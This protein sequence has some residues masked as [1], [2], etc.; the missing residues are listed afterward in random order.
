MMQATFDGMSESATGHCSLGPPTPK[1]IPGD[2]SNVGATTGVSTQL[3]GLRACGMCLQVRHPVP[4]PEAQPTREGSTFTLESGC[5][6]LTFLVCVVGWPGDDGRRQ[7]GGGL[8]ER[9]VRVVRLGRPQPRRA[10][11]R[12]QSQYGHTHKTFIVRTKKIVD[13]HIIHTVNCPGSNHLISVA[14]LIDTFMVP[15][16]ID[17]PL[18]CLCCR[19]FVSSYVA[20]CCVVCVCVCV[21]LVEGRAV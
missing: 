20:L 1:G 16:R 19:A 18:G 13:H 8:R 17:G 3:Y 7:A 2:L 11:R 10:G 14:E 12:P 5:V 6:S 9:R 21:S 15:V 4:Q